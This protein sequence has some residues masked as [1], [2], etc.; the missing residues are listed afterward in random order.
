MLLVRFGPRFI[1]IKLKM[2]NN[3]CII[4]FMFVHVFDI[5]FIDVRFLFL[6]LGVCV[7]TFAVFVSLFFF[8]WN[9]GL[10]DLADCHH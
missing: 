6:G 2:S 5:C 10:V 1:L 9:L 7:I 4:C 3:R 8:F